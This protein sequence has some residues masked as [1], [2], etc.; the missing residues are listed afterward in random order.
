MPPGP[1]AQF[2][3]FRLPTQADLAQ[4]VQLL[5][6]SGLCRCAND[7]LRFFQQHFT[8]HPAAAASVYIMSDYIF[9][10]DFCVLFCF[11]VVVFFLTSANE[12]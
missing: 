2:S 3:F 5:C 11:L 8:A 4:A 6:Y 9:L 10:A 7:L 12:N 1:H